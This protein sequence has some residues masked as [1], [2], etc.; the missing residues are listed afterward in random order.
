MEPIRRIGALC[1]GLTCYAIFF[2]TF[3]YLIG[4]AGNFVV[5]KTIDSGPVGDLGWSLLIDVGLLVLF[6]LQHSVMARPAWK[7]PFTAVIPRA[8]ERSTY[9]LAS[10]AVLILLYWQWRPLPTAIFELQG[11][12]AGALSA[13][14]LLGYAIVLESTFLIDHFDL[15]G[16]RQVF[17][18]A[19]GRPYTEKRFATPLL[20]RHIRHPLYLGWL[21]TFWATPRLSVG[22]LVFASV[23]TM[24]I[25][26][27][28]P[29]EESDLAE[30]LGEPY[31]AWRERTP[32]FLPRF[33]R[34]D[35]TPVRV[36]QGAR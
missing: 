33:R 28:I 20:Y 24:Y 34:A 1:Y 36:R 30:Q 7:R 27:A 35:R 23:L 31:L 12:G 8:L 9:V 21:I 19:V 15:F 2:V 32:M 13:L 6:G 14:Y 4:F 26:V 25:L 29:F 10:S 5:P 11:F 3:L 16:L 22:H 18:R 17:L